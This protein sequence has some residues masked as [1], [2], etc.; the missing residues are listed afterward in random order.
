MKS[1]EI[2]NNG[3][4]IFDDSGLHCRENIMVLRNFHE[5]ITSLLIQKMSPRK[6]KT[7]VEKIY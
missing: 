5:Y 1:L 6:C 3:R 4:A 2:I 7:A